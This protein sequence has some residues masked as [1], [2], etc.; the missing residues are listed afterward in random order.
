MRAALFHPG[1]FRWLALA[2]LG[3]TLPLLVATLHGAPDWILARDVGP[4][5]VG[6]GD[7]GPRDMSPTNGVRPEIATSSPVRPGFVP[8]YVQ[9]AAYARDDADASLNAIEAVLGQLAEND[10]A[11]LR[12][13][14]LA[15]RRAG[16]ALMSRPGSQP[17]DPLV[18]ELLMRRADNFSE[19]LAEM[20]IPQGARTSLDA[21][22][23]VYER[24]VLGERYEEAEMVRSP[25]V[26]PAVG[27]R[28]MAAER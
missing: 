16:S 3:V 12:E 22:L 13:P 24:T 1:P 17:A 25:Q 23:A 19:R 20:N 2:A 11:A 18:C 4:G 6:P 8:A 26:V 5:D 10:E 9:T 14:M 27:V 15:A 28:T 7:V 21:S